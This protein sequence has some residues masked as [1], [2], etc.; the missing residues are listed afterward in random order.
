MEL[1]VL[2]SIAWTRLHIH[3]YSNQTT[4]RCPVNSIRISK[5][6]IVSEARSQNVFQDKEKKI[7]T[8]KGVCFDGANILPRVSLTIVKSDGFNFSSMHA[9]YEFNVTEF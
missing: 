6:C 8:H 3:T 9:G 4:Y 5:P 1:M 7:F 2:A